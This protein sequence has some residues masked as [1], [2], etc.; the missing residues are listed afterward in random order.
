MLNV[1]NVRR[2][3]RD[4][5]QTHVVS[6]PPEVPISGQEICTQYDAPAGTPTT[7]G[8]TRSVAA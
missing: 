8:G 6:L 4:R 3:A 5:I 7:S 2:V 1:E